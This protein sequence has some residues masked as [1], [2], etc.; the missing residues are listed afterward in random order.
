MIPIRSSMSSP[1]RALVTGVTGFIGNHLA[2]RLLSDG[3]QVSAIVR[4]SSGGNRIP[5]G[6]IVHQHDGTTQDMLRIFA[7]AKPV[8][9][10]HLAS[11][12]LARHVPGDVESLV[13]SNL[14]FGLQL[15]EAATA[16]GCRNV[17]NA[18][19]GWQ[20]FENNDYDPVCLYAATKQAFEDL[21]E[22][23][24]SVGGVKMA[25][26]KLHDTYGNSD[27]RGKLVSLLLNAA[28]NGTLLELSPGEQKIDLVHIDDVV[29]AFLAASIFLSG[30]GTPGH[31]RF[32]VSS[33][34]AV[35]IRELAGVIE[36]VTGK[37]I[38]AKWG[39]RPYREREVMLPWNRGPGVPGWMPS[40]PLEEGMSKLWAERERAAGSGT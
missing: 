18:G 8:T 36:R 28:C 15:L 24:V 10:F 34:K 6:C 39:A 38:P 25:T 13:D 19:T 23:Y 20:H 33:G 37:A 3:W 26:L 35:S 9:V 7:E 27:P 1:Q 16:I 31:H 12:F 29:S 14:L 4:P 40:V 2:R 11:K 22:Y 21:A 5:E 32:M 17:V 30:E